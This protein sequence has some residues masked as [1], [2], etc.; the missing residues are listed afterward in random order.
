MA[1]DD[2]M[3]KLELRLERIE[4]LMERAVTARQA[5]PLSAEEIAAY[6]KVRDVIATDYGEFCG[7]NDCFRCIIVRCV[8]I[9][10]VLCDRICIRPC[11]IE[12]TC[13]PCGFSGA[14]RG[15]VRRFG[16]LGG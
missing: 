15:G 6:R 1:D 5:E 16:V 9:C 13:G 10:Q 3:S 14:A 12:C 7:I 11:D 8:R 4:K 2:R